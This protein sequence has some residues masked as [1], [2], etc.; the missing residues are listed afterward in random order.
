MLAGGEPICS[1]IESMPGRPLTMV[2]PFRYAHPVDIDDLVD[3]DDETELLLATAT[4]S[5]SSRL[6]APRRYGKTSLLRR[7]LGEAAAEGW[8]GVYVD[9]YG[10]LT[11]GDVAERVERAYAQ[12]LT[13]RAAR[14]F[15]GVRAAFAPTVS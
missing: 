11:L 9:F 12:A 1:R 8:T 14:W 6:V 4:E 2:N 15:D 3:R 13:G 7:V 10:V 5:N